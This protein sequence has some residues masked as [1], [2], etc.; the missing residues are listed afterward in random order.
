M[1]NEENDDTSVMLKQYR[2][3]IEL[4]ESKMR[5]FDQ[6][7]AQRLKIQQDYA[8]LQ[9]ELEELRRRELEKEVT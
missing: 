1:V 2:L 6:M 8:R 3:K 5:N 7:N 4:L 9:E